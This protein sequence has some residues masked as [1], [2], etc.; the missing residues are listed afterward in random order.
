MQVQNYHYSNLHLILEELVQAC[1]DA[2]L[3]HIT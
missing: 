2:E 3:S 1:Y